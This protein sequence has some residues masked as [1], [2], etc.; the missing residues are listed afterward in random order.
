MLQRPG[1]FSN[2][3]TPCHCGAVIASGCSGEARSAHVDLHPFFV[4]RDGKRRGEA[5]RLG[6][7]FS[8]TV[9]RK[10]YGFPFPVDCGARY[11]VRR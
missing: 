10:F 3:G 11:E 4:R 1:E 6:T 5:S 7:G 9:R 2:V 8:T